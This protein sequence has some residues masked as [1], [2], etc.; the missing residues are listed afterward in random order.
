VTIKTDS[1]AAQ[2]TESITN[3]A[4]DI[5]TIEISGKGNSVSINQESKGKVEVKQRGNNNSIK[6]SQSNHQP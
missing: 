3:K 4:K 1:L 2:T 5:N 6:I